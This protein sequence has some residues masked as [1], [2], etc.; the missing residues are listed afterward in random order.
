MA[1]GAALAVMFPAV[2]FVALRGVNCYTHGRSGMLFAMALDKFLQVLAGVRYMFPQRRNGQ[3]RVFRLADIEKLAVRLAGAVQVTREDQME[4][5]VTVAVDVEFFQERQHDGTIGGLIECGM[6]TP[7]PPAPGLHIRIILQRLFVLTKD[8]CSALKIF[9][10]HVCDRAAQHVALQDRARFEQLHDLVRRKSRN[11]SASIWDYGDET[12]SRQMA[13]SFTD[14]NTAGLK[15]SSNGVLPKLFTFT[16]FAAENFF[17]EP[18]DNSSRKRLPRD[19]GRLFWGD[20]LHDW[21]EICKRQE[22]G[23]F[24]SPRPTLKQSRNEIQIIKPMHNLQL[25][26]TELTI[27]ALKIPDD[28]HFS[29][30]RIMQAR[31]AVITLGSNLKPY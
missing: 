25:S 29:T 28:L 20:C 21:V 13:E 9:F 23:N 10:L 12:F 27:S 4:T 7:V 11:N 24:A 18:F 22:T 15:F 6:E 30:R 2:Q 26:S 14:R 17:C 19:R 5:G 8:V 31:L 1:A 3:I 16:Q